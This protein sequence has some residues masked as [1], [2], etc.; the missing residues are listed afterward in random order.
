MCW[1]NLAARCSDAVGWIRQSP[2]R[3][4]YLINWWRRCVQQS[5]VES[6]CLK[7]FER[8][9]L[10]P[11]MDSKNRS[12]INWKSAIEVEATIN[13]NDLEQIVLPPILTRQ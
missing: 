7:C 1:P 9:Q 13:S 3:R 2:E 12:T 10:P 4:I 8:I 6:C 5:T 11:D